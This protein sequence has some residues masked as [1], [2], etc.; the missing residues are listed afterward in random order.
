MWKLLGFSTKSCQYKIFC[1]QYIMASTA[2]T[3]YTDEGKQDEGKG[4]D[5]NNA[6]YTVK[7]SAFVSQFRRTHM[8]VVLMTNSKNEQLISYMKQW[9]VNNTNGK[10]KDIITKTSQSYSGMTYVTFIGA[11]YSANLG[12]D[13]SDMRYYNIPNVNI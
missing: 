3:S 12:Q 2:A 6:R 4:D 9:F 1:L 11:R 10:E 13:I 7:L 8:D 5:T